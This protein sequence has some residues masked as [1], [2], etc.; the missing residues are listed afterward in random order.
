MIQK[1]ATAS[2]LANTNFRII[3]G[4]IAVVNTEISNPSSKLQY[5]FFR[6]VAV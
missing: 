4:L 2:V 3:K 1:E 5:R 6:H